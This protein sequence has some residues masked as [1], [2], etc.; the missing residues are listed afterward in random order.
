MN[1]KRHPEK[2]QM[3]LSASAAEAL[4]RYADLTGTTRVTAGGFL[5]T[6]YVRDELEAELVAQDSLVLRK[7]APL[8]ISLEQWVSRNYANV[9]EDVIAALHTVNEFLE[10]EGARPFKVGD[11]LA[12]TPDGRQL[13]VTRVKKDGSVGG[14]RWNGE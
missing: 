14:T 9:P 5:I 4:G 11:V 3:T 7:R 10:S 12:T 1:E 2:F 8:E 6:K 13:V